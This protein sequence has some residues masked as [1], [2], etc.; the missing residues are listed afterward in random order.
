MTYLWESKIPWERFRCLIPAESGLR[1]SRYLL[2]SKIVLRLEELIIYESVNTRNSTFDHSL[3]SLA[4]ELH[5]FSNVAGTLPETSIFTVAVDPVLQVQF[6]VNSH[7]ATLCLVGI[8]SAK[9]CGQLPC[10]YFTVHKE[11]IRWRSDK[12][13][14]YKRKTPGE[15]HCF[16]C[17]LISGV[18][19][20]IPVSSTVTKRRRNSFGLRLNGVKHCS[21]VVSRL[22]LLSGVSKRGTHR[23][24]SF[25]MSNISCREIYRLTT[26]RRDTYRIAIIM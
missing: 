18:F 22:R 8:C 17:S 2:R 6:V 7:E 15:V 16:Y 23:A 9:W 10:N 21:E 24:D 5:R 26:R 20:W 1:T 13:L 25:L 11:I 14:S 12:Y 19:R 3:T 4:H